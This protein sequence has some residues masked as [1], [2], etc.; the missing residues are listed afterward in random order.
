MIV[1]PLLLMVRYLDGDIPLSDDE[2][3]IL[4]FA[5]YMESLR[6]MDGLALQGVAE[7]KKI[8]KKESSKLD[9]V[10][11]THDEGIHIDVD[12]SAT[13]ENV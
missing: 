5:L 10:G 6:N 13:M 12:E 7:L 3:E 1:D 4:L 2:R 8:G 9:L 11:G